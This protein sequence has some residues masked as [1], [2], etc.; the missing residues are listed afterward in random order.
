MNEVKVRLCWIKLPIIVSMIIEAHECNTPINVSRVILFLKRQDRREQFSL[1]FYGRF[2][3]PSA[4]FH[5]QKRETNWTRARRWKVKKK[6]LLVFISSR[7]WSKNIVQKFF[8][9]RLKDMCNSFNGKK[10][11]HDARELSCAGKGNNVKIYCR[12]FNA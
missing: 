10:F 4:L 9:A 11:T 1:I 8:S 6:C 7:S 5:L 2:P 12:H 3:L